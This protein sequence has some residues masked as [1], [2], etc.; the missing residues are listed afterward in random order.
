MNM[1]PAKRNSYLEHLHEEVAR[2]VLQQGIRESD[3]RKELA[4]ERGYLDWDAMVRANGRLTANNVRVAKAYERAVRDLNIDNP[5]SLE[6]VI[7]AMGSRGA[8]VRS[9]TAGPRAS[10]IQTRGSHEAR[11]IAAA[12][13]AVDYTEARVFEALGHPALNVTA[14]YLPPGAESLLLEARR[15]LPEIPSKE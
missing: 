1:K 6:Q 12:M 11:R 13:F 8:K 15:F 10:V 7:K 4:E 2:R 9:R 5:P 14:S 3:A